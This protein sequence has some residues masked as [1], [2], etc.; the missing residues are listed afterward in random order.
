MKWRMGKGRREGKVH[1]ATFVSP[2]TGNLFQV[3]QN[4]E[5]AVNSQAGDSSLERFAVQELRVMGTVCHFSRT[6]K[7]FEK[8]LLG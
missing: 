5:A 1:S 6:V 3:A 7:I 4:L 2:R 8:K